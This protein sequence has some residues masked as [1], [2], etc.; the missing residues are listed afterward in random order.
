MLASTGLVTKQRTG[1]NVPAIPAGFRTRW[2]VAFAITTRM[3]AAQEDWFTKKR[4]KKI[5]SIV[6]G[7]LK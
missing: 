3:S 6:Y 5:I 7:D 2:D 1:G 4:E